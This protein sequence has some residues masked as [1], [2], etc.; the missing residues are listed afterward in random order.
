MYL[1]IDL[2]TSNSAVAGLRNGRVTVFKT[3]EG[4]DVMPSVIYRDRHGNQTVGVRAY[5][6]LM[7]A[8][9]NVVH[10]FKRLMGTPTPQ[11]FASTG[12]SLSPEEASAEV[13]RAMIGYAAIEAGGSAATG[14]VVT[15]PAAFNQMQ[16]EATLA[17]AHAAG[18]D[19]VALLQEPVAAAMAA[20]AGAVNR[21]GLFLI[22]DLGGGTFDVALVQAIDGA[23]TVLS[24]EGVNMLGGRDF[25]RLI[26]DNV[27]RPWL[28]R[29]FDL[30]EN[31]QADK[32]YDR[33]LRVARR[34]AENAKIELSA[35][36]TTTITA[37]DEFIR[38]DDRAGEAIY[39]NVPI[40]RVTLDRLVNDSVTQSI[41]LCRKV[42]D[43]NGYTH[44]DISR[45]VLIGGPTKM[46]TIR[47]RVSDEL[48]I[49]A[50]DVGRV[51]PM[52]A[53]A[54]GAAIYCESRDWSQA[55]SMP[56]PARASVVTNGAIS[57]AYAFETRT[58]AL[59]ARLT[60]TA[61]GGDTAATVQVDSKLGWSSGRRSLVNPVMLDLDLPDFGPNTFSALVF[62][63]SGRPVSQASRKIVIE[64][65]LAATSGIPATQTIAVKL[66]DDA[67]EANTLVVLVPKGT[68]LPQ[69]G[70]ARYRIA[71]PLR[72]GD[73]GAIRIELF[74]MDDDRVP[75]PELNLAIGEFRIEGAELPPGLVLRRGDDVIVHWGMSDSQHFTAEIEIPR[76]R[77]RFEGRNF[78][79]HQASPDSYEAEDGAALVGDLLDRATTELDRAADAMPSATGALLTPLRQRLNEQRSLA[80][81]TA[82]PDVRRSIAESTRMIRQTI[83]AACR[84]PAARQQLLRQRLA[85]EMDWY[86][87]RVRPGAAPSENERADTLARGARL[88]IEAGD[89][90]SLHT[91]DRQIR[92][93]GRLSWDAGLKQFGFCAGIWPYF[94][95][96]RHLA[97]DRALFDQTVE[98]GD[99]ALAEG[100]LEQLRSAIYAMWRN[101][102]A[103]DVQE[104]VRERASLMLR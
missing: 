24:H 34:A 19:R 97:R 23:V 1:G 74:Q 29:S 67:D 21:S 57:V 40:D 32:H 48:G 17:A 102:R 82:D 18:L 62:D 42:L 52:T 45:V 3:P 72:A 44:E 99:A 87:N 16:S 38:L 51:D 96:T 5:D 11:R 28:L 92:E 100:E 91:A 81:D 50:E 31:L 26:V 66:R 7:L 2:G 94:R 22:Y 10:G 65:T 78:Y 84:D 6:Q 86:A 36:E 53:V 60:V 101:R 4:T 35:R 68:I 56:K 47:R 49:A 80:E 103:V 71:E 64:R 59:Q 85:N 25:D 95:D 61:T 8:P 55:T 58:T 83:A 76:A 63:G 46:P 75:D 33:L 14:T 37:G 79:D 90:G 69:S 88:A 98:S 13:L 77:Q 27:V 41:A 54:F 70:V 93:I 15:I 43:D 39:L 30:P 12:A 89:G 9:S 73:A 20:I 104:H